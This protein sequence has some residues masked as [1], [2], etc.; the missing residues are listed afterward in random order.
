MQCPKCK[1]ND[2]R[3]LESR[4][5][6]G[7]SVRRRRECPD[8]SGRFTTY[9]RLERPNIAVIKKDGSRELFNRDKLLHALDKSVGKFFDSSLEVENLA[10]KIEDYIHSFN[11]Q[12][13]KSKDIGDAILDKLLEINEIAY[14]RFASVYNNFTCLED[15]ED[16]LKR[17][18]QRGQ[19]G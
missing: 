6:A 1:S 4:D 19:T 14:I 7:P 2:T 11:E 17:V 18:R 13:I 12:Q 3:V 10:G 8:C 15:F 5:A 9:E 16:A